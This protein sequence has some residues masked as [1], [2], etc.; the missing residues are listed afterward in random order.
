[1]DYNITF[2]KYN[3]NTII[4][5]QNDKIINMISCPPVK[6]GCDIINFN[7]ELYKGYIYNFDGLILITTK[8]NRKIY[9]MGDMIAKTKR[10]KRLLKI[11]AKKLKLKKIND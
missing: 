6:K 8:Y 11:I 5:K 7:V 4:I 1:M 3:N 10:K 9:Y 2:D